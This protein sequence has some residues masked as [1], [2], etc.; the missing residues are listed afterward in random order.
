MS[1]GDNIDTK[2]IAGERIFSVF[3]ASG[4]SNKLV[5]IIRRMLLFSEEEFNTTLK[6]YG[7]DTV[8]LSTVDKNNNKEIS[9]EEFAIWDQ[10]I[11]MQDAVK[12]FVANVI[13]KDLIGELAQYQQPIIAELKNYIEEFANSYGTKNID[14]ML[15]TYILE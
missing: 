14:K 6:E 13:S 4:I 9:E 11:L 10:K 2:N 8:E 7:L 15:A 5:E 12:D 1:K 3:S